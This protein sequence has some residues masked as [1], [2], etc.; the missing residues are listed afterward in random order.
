MHVSGVKRQWFLCGMSMVRVQLEALAEW[1]LAVCPA[2]NRYLVVTVVMAYI[3]NTGVKRLIKIC[4][5]VSTLNVR[6]YYRF[7]CQARRNGIGARGASKRKR[8]PN[9]ISE[10]CEPITQGNAPEVLLCLCGT[11]SS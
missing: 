8:V 3:E 1:S 2:R 6:P 11:Y 10:K 7:C 9:S 5:H 4:K